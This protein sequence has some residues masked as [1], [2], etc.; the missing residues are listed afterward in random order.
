MYGY[1]YN[2]TR[3]NIQ[4]NNNDC[5]ICLDDGSLFELKHYSEFNNDCSCNY[6]IHKPCLVSWIKKKR[7]HSCCLLCST[8]MLNANEIADINTR[9]TTEYHSRRARVI[10]LTLNQ[11]LNPTEDNII[12]IQPNVR[13]EQQQNALIMNN[14]EID[15]T[16]MNNEEETITHVI[17]R[18]NT[19]IIT[20]IIFFILFAFILS[21][22]IIIYVL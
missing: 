19:R 9:Q 21:G 22:I 1:N 16:P 15:V 20:A 4:E 12:Q 3:V 8:P 18:S 2:P 17:I 11:V 7:Q 14:Q 5:I 6:Y 13:E 10:R